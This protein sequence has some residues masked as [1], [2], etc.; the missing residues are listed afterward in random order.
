MRRLFRILFA[1]VVSVAL[2]VATPVLHG[3]AILTAANADPAVNADAEKQAFESAKELGTSDAWQAFLK[4]YATGFRADLARAYLKKLGDTQNATPAASGTPTGVT[5]SA[6]AEEI[7]CR[8][9]QDAKSQPS[10]AAA[11]ITFINKSGAT[12]V[13]LWKS[14]DGGYK[15]YATLEDGKEFTQETFLTHPW[16]AANGPGDC[17]Q[18]FMPIP[19]SSVAILD[20]T[21]DDVAAR[22]QADEDDAAASKKSKKKSARNDDG[23]DHGPTPEQTC[24]DI[25]QVYSDGVCVSKKKKK[26][27]R[28]AKASCIELGMAYRN[29]QCVAKAQKDIQQFKKQ[30]KIGCPKGTYLNPLGVCQSDETG[31]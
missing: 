17:A 9:A 31:G 28:S 27:E 1:I 15:E 26:S 6:R 4:S 3:A 8:V 18:A 29:G 7:P 14:F 13:I 12:R 5:S 19:G 16:I 21:N 11:K 20:V 2:G 24:R 22:L 30:K 23:D 10:T 25:G